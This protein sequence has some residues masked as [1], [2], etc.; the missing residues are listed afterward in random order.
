M[1]SENYYKH[2]FTSE[3]STSGFSFNFSFLHIFFFEKFLYT[4]LFIHNKAFLT[5]LITY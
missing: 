1:F 5:Q 2:I 4:F 3:M